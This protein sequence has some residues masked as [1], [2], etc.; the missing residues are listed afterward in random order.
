M[1][2]TKVVNQTL[3]HKDIND[4]VDFIFVPWGNAYCE[5]S[6]C[7][8]STPGVFEH[9]ARV[10]WNSKCGAVD[11]PDECFSCVQNMSQ[12][13]DSG[14]GEC[15]GNRVEGCS[16]LLYPQEIWLAF[17]TCFEG[18]HQGDLSFAEPC[19][20]DSGVDFQAL[21]D[22][23]NSDVGVQIDYMN[24]KHTCTMPHSGTPWVLIN[25]KHLE[26]DSAAGLL[27]AICG[28]LPQAS[29]PVSCLAGR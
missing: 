29:Q 26:D 15:I 20:N 25:G 17:L 4:V 11:A 13:C 12:T 6:I 5:T 23:V 1:N 7:P 16:Q 22:C 24:A 14:H 28:A 9:D 19:A 2:F 21:F 10:C 3:S 18:H 27:N 8:S